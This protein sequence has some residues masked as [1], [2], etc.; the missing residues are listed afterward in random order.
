[1]FYNFRDKPENVAGIVPSLLELLIYFFPDFKT[2]NLVLG[3]DGKKHGEEIKQIIHSYAPCT[4]IDLGQVTTPCLADFVRQNHYFGIQV[5]ASHLPEWFNGLKIFMP[6]GKPISVDIEQQILESVKPIKVSNSKSK[7]VP[8]SVNIAYL[9]KL[10]KQINQLQEKVG[11]IIY[12]GT[13]PYLSFIQHNDLI[14]EDKEPDPEKRN[15]EWKIFSQTPFV[16]SID[17]DADKCIIYRNGIRINENNIIAV[18]TRALKAKKLITNHEFSDVITSYLEEQMVT[19]QKVLVGDQFIIERMDVNGD[20]EFGAEPNGHYILPG[21]LCSDA[22][23]A[24]LTYIRSYYKFNNLPQNFYTKEI[25]SYQ[26]N[27]QAE[28]EFKALKK[29]PHSKVCDNS[30]LLNTIEKCYIR[31]SGWETSLVVVLEGESTNEVTKYLT[32]EL[33][34]KVSYVEN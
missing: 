9:Q 8:T 31:K 21:T 23:L 27:N 14:V 3:Y 29:L 18:I 11:W 24:A 34:R 13:A 25:Y 28:K 2:T 22:I 6:N 7:S 10:Q 33:N 1:M 30:I 26:S 32:G 19:V 4:T 20:T 5:T 17:G 16:V 12:K 15:P